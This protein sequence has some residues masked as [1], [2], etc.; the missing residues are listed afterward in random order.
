MYP[1]PFPN[2]TSRNTLFPLACFL[3]IFP[4]S[5]LNT[6][7]QKYLSPF[8]PVFS[9]PPFLFPNSTSRNTFLV[10]LLFFLFPKH[11]VQKRYF[12]HS[13]LLPFPRECFS[14]FPVFPF[15]PFFPF[16]SI[17]LRFFAFFEAFNIGLV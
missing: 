3:S 9:D 4:L 15:F 10:P 6:S 1:V 13:S 2:I 5:I 12:L 16:F 11:Y 7:F 14:L 8:P 17:S